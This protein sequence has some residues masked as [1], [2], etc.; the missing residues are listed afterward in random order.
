MACNTRNLLVASAGV[1]LMGACPLIAA[2]GAGEHE[3]PGLLDPDPGSAVWTI[4]LFILLVLLLGRF[5]W[6][7]ILRGLQDRE[8]KIR[9][10]LENAERSAKDAQKTLGEYQQRLAAANEE[11]R[12]IIDQGRADA[13]KIVSQLKQQTQDEI[14]QMRN[15]AEADISAAQ[16]QALNEIYVQTATLATEVAGRILKRQIS[17]DDQQRLVRDALEEMG[18]TTRN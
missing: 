12:Q 4:V 5:A 16:E 9:G 10:D 2:N 11:V 15:R 8:A 6:P 17:V 1:L 13:Q 7:A 14:G 3:P 18:R